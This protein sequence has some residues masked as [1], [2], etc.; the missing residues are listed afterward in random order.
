MRSRIHRSRDDLPQDS[1]GTF[2]S[3]RVS[4]RGRGASG[5]N[6]R[7]SSWHTAASSTSKKSSQ[8]P[9]EYTVELRPRIAGHDTEMLPAVATM[10]WLCAVE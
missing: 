3:S 7:T 6:D 8:K 2:A 10:D 4:T 1:R 5:L 9:G